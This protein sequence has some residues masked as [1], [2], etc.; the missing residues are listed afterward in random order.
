MSK[1]VRPEVPVSSAVKQRQLGD[2]ILRMKYRFD[3]E[4]ALNPQWALSE[5][6]D[7]WEKLL[8][9]VRNPMTVYQKLSPP[10][11]AQP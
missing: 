3:Y 11:E 1:I 2:E 6:L 4:L 8:A 7:A 9:L 5:R 10:A